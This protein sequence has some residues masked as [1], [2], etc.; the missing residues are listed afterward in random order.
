M[1]KLLT[2]RFVAGARAATRQTYF[3]VKTRGLVLRV[4]PLRKTWLFVYRNGG[5]PRW[6]RLGTYPAM[7]LAEAR[8]A[9][10][11]ERKLLEVDRV[12]PAGKRREQDQVPHALTV[13]GFAPSFIQFQQR[14]VKNWADDKTTL[15]RH[16]LPAWGPR[17]LRSL[18]RAD[19][20]ELLDSLAGK[21]LTTGVNRVQSLVSRLFAVALDRGLVDAHPAS[22]VMK[23]FKEVPRDRVLGDDELRALWTGLDDRPGDASDALRL[24]LLLGQRGEET[25]GMQWAELDLATATWSIPRPRTKTSQPHVLGIPPT[26]LALLRQRREDVP[27]E[28]PHVFPGLTLNNREYTALSV[29]HG[30]AY[31]WKDLR[32]T[33]ATRLAGLGFDET[34]IGRVLNHARYTVT[35]R[36]YN[37]HRYAE[38][39]RAALTAW[40]E[41]LQRILSGKPKKR[42][43]V[44]PMRARP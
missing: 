9:A 31:Q 13:A 24:R 29:I 23:R 41:E 12:D 15:E 40:D 3:D 37:Q 10:L 30:G 26:A 20:N 25:T 33:V 4:G 32:R 14:R 28:Q 2:D 34:V 44:L 21:G 17:P 42:S 19:V 38:E 6:L 8:A 16:I 5:P 36:H 1:T 35:G 18:T 43:H 11:A 7:P 27:P 39:I 22:R